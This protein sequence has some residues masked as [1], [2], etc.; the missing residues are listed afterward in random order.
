MNYTVKFAK[1]FY[2]TV[3]VRKPMLSKHPAVSVN[4]YYRNSLLHSEPE[5]VYQGL[6][7]ENYNTENAML[8]AMCA[9]ERTL[10]RFPFTYEDL[11]YRLE[12][13][14]NDNMIKPY[15]Y[16]LFPIG[17]VFEVKQFL[18]NKRAEVF[19]VLENPEQGT[20]MTSDLVLLRFPE[21]KKK[22]SQTLKWDDG[23]L[24]QL[25]YRIIGK[26]FKVLRKSNFNDDWKVEEL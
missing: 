16:F 9:L 1:D 6:L 10:S 20:V 12:Y 17:S 8:V 13:D 24:G 23:G 4:V 3:S 2:A 7:Y 14:R 26:R 22:Y 11:P 21:I 19:L 15:P 5:K 18:I 25:S